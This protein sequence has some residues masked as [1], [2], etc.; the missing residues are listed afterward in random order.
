[1]ERVPIFT[2]PRKASP[3]FARYLEYSDFP[4]KLLLQ[5]GVVK[6]L[7]KTKKNQ[8]IYPIVYQDEQFCSDY[9]ARIKA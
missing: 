8:D 1:M 2:A 4:K 6:I 3:H 9:T 7:I 5:N